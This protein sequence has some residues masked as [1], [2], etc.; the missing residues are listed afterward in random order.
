MSP[1][2][3]FPFGFTVSKEGTLSGADIKQG[4]EGLIDEIFNSEPDC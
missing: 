2:G 4:F 3:G 1:S